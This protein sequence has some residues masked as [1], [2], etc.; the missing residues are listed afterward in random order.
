MGSQQLLFLLIGIIIVFTV[1]GFGY[2]LFDEYSSDDIQNEMVSGS[3]QL[4]ID[5]FTN[6]KRNDSHGG[7]GSKTFENW[8]PPA[9]LISNENLPWSVLEYSCDE[10]IA[11]ISLKSKMKNSDGNEVIIS[12]KIN[13]EGKKQLLLWNWESRTWKA[14]VNEF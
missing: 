6:Y 1:L 10:T 2:K 4:L 12:A 7:G 13:G 3:N 14:I 5:A 9:N 8:I 11:H